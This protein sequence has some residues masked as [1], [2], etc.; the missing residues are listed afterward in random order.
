MATVTTMMTF[1]IC[2]P[3]ECDYAYKC[4]IYFSTIEF[5]NTDHVT[6]SYEIDNVI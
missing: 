1:M 5:P 2:L 3:Y 6:P 4:T